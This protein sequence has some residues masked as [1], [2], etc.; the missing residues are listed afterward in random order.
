MPDVGGIKN[1]VFLLPSK[2][3]ARPQHRGVSIADRPPY[4]SRVL[5]AGQE[6]VGVGGVDG[7]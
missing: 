5:G 6:E 3:S 2:M 7:P 4:P 1:L